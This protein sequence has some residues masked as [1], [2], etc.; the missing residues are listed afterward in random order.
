M[1]LID[2]RLDR[3]RGRSDNANAMPADLFAKLTRHIAATG[4]YPAL[5]VR[6]CPD[7]PDAFE[8]LDGHHR[9]AALRQLGAVTARCDVW[10]VDDQQALILLTTLNRLEGRDDPFRRA[11]LLAKLRQEMSWESLAALLPESRQRAEQTLALLDDPPEPAAPPPPDDLPHAL[12]FFLTGAQQRRLE[13]HLA[14][15]SGTRSQRL[16]ALLNLDDPEVQ[17]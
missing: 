13:A 11:A 1:N 7:E 2:V 3:L 15:H 8:I 9:A 6:P 17:P 10:E 4:Q 5:I 16:I 14:P 12:T